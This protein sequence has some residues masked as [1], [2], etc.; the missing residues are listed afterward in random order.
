VRIHRIVSGGQT[1]ADRAAL[2]A[3]IAAG[4]PYAGWC[5]A[6]GLAE[7]LTEPPGLLAVYPGLLEAS[8]PD[9]AV[10]TRLNVRD[11]HATLVV[12]SPEDDPDGG[13]RGRHASTGSPGTDLTVATAAE[14]G[15]P[16]LVSSDADAVLRWLDTLGHELT[17]GVAGPRESEQP[18]TYARARVLLEEVLRRDG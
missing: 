12:A 13:P 8:S 18:G 1:G 3:A 15:R 5:P 6:G 16:C 11:S 9:P 17:L 14:L 4:R 10:R 7:D 2:D